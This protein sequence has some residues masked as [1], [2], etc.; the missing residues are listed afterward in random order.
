MKLINMDLAHR[1]CPAPVD[2]FDKHWHEAQDVRLIGVRLATALILTIA[3]I[4]LL[5]Q[6][7]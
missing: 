1:R 4:A 6:V 7:A 5:V 2:E 3:A